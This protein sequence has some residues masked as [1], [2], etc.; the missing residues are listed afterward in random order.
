MYN[1]YIW[2]FSL[3]TVHLKK[4]HTAFRS[5][6]CT[7]G[8]SSNTRQIQKDKKLRSCTD[9]S[10]SI[11]HD[12]KNNSLLI[13]I[14]LLKFHRIVTVHCPHGQWEPEILDH[15]ISDHSGQ[16]LYINQAF[17]V[18]SNTWLTTCKW[19]QKSLEMAKFSTCRKVT[20]RM[21]KKPY[22]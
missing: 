14:Q 2:L 12:S 21:E 15:D 17:S 19:K 3:V 18:I 11:Q 20:E 5:L 7:T 9:R 16:V 4:W 10:H 13:L 8:N 6:M 22:L 1:Y